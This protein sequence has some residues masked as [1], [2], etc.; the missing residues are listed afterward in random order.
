ML[1]VL[2]KIWLCF[3]LDNDCLEEHRSL[4]SLYDVKRDLTE[5]R[6]LTS[7]VPLILTRR[8][9]TE[10]AS[11]MAQPQ[12][13]YESLCREVLQLEREADAHNANHEV[14]SDGATSGSAAARHGLGVDRHKLAEDLAETRLCFLGRNGVGKTT[15]LERWIL[16]GQV[17]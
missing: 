8:D 6:R 13:L 9:A 15:T 10:L 3:D 1:V 14:E 16:L 4:K 5:I 11:T 2:C 7:Y 17:G 12:R